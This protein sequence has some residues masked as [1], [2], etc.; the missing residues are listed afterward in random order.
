MVVVVVAE[1][2]VAGWRVAGGGWRV[3]GW[4]GDRPGFDRVAGWRRAGGGRKLTVYDS[5]HFK[6]T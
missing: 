5:Q 3:A 4:W 6:D 1:R 2:Q